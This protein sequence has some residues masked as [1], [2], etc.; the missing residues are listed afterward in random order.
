FPQVEQP[1][2]VNEYRQ[3]SKGLVLVHPDGKVPNLCHYRVKIN[4]TVVL[5]WFH[6]TIGHYREYHDR[7]WYL[8]DGYRMGLGTLDLK[9]GEEISVTDF[10]RPFSGDLYSFFEEV[11]AK[12]GEVMDEIN[13]I[14]KGPQ[15]GHDIFMIG[16]YSVLD[17]IRWSSEL[18][19]EGLFFDL[20]APFSVWGDYRVRNEKFLPMNQGGAITPTELKEYYALQRSLSPR[21][22]PSTYHIVI[23]ATKGARVMEEHPEWFRKYDRAGKIDSLFPG[24]YENYQTMF[25]YPECRQFLIDTLFDY[26]YFNNEKSIYLDEAQMTNTIDWQHLTVT[27][28][29]HTVLFWKALK[30]RAVKEGILLFFNGSGN[31]YADINFMESPHEMAPDRWRDWVGVAWGI[32]MM[33]RLKPGNRAV[34]L[35]WTAKTDYVNRFLALGWIPDPYIA[36]ATFPPMRAQFETGHLLPVRIKHSPDW[37]QDFS[38][39]VESHTMMRPASNER[40]VSYISRASEPKDVAVTIDLGSLG[41]TTDTRINVWRLTP[42]YDKANNRNYFLA[43]R[44]L[45]ANWRN[46]GWDD[47]N[48]MM[49]PQ[50]AYSGP[51]TGEFKQTLEQLAP[52]AMVQFL[53]VPGPASIRA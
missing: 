49:A 34:P 20:S 10:L 17:Y 42:R 4:D 32:G 44:E 8:P 50:L 24:A 46:Y 38:I 19:D 31:P 12:D 6:S 47:G 15:W 9:S 13:S 7:L 36:Y 16:G 5:P 48:A 21:A 33:N 29:D 41:Y 14:P 30:A 3:S 43:D 53:F 40:L 28:D 25:C 52:N 39:E 23:A 27:R 37:M 51:A 26:T 2:P 18:I 1:R 11:F 22:L 45:K 35:Y